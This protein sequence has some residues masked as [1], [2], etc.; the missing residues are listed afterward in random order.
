MFALDVSGL[1]MAYVA[2]AALLAVFN[3]TARWSWPIK[4]FATVAISALYLVAYF[5]F[6]AL[7]GWPTAQPL[8]ARFRL[9]AA[10]VEPADGEP[11]EIVLWALDADADAAHAEPRAYRLPY[12]ELTQKKVAEAG[13]RIRKGLPQI[14]EVRQR[15]P[16][17]LASSGAAAGSKRA[18][19]QSGKA[20]ETNVGGQA[21]AALE[22]QDLPAPKF[23]GK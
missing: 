15:K 21:S 5:S 1:T 12:S 19:G 17:S 3:L 11:R 8:P 14:G 20:S 22:F 7:L 23:P 10:Q 9:L 18:G 16:G 6:P 13:E 2:V 4:A